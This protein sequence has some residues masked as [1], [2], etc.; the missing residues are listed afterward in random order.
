MGASSSKAARRLPTK[1]PSAVHPLPAAT[2]VPPP[3][4]V[5]EAVEQA[6]PPPS[7][8]TRAAD[9]APQEDFVYGGLRELPRGSSGPSFSGEKD[10]G[11][12]SRLH[13]RA[14][15]TLPAILKDAMD[16]QFMANLSRL[17]PVAVP[18]ASRLVRTVRL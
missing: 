9:A 7:S 13:E 3:P 4:P 6:V 12:Y 16:P 18:Q 15:L 5:S 2:R 14:E 11:E 8:S 17:G 10:D 1:T